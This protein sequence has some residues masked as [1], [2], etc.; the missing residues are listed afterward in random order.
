MK[1][2]QQRGLKRAMKVLKRKRKK[3]ML[4]KIEKIK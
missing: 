2:K 3:R 1:Q 4:N